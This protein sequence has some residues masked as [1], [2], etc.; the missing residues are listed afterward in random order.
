MKKYV[1][2]FILGLLTFNMNAGDVNDLVLII[3][4]NVAPGAE[5][6]EVVSIIFFDS[7]GKQVTVSYTY[8]PITN[9][10]TVHAT[11]TY[12]IV[13]TDKK[14]GKTRTIHIGSTTNS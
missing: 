14:T 9:T 7:Q 11:G 2:F 10:L 12:F 3:N 6:T 4:P 1:L 8:D 13:I 5:A